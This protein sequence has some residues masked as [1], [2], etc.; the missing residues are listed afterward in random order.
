MGLSSF[1]ELPFQYTK[2]HGQK[3]SENPPPPQPENGTLRRVGSPYDD[4][5]E[6]G[7]KT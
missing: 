3:R 5:I 7:K 1:R 6:G 2:R 4:G